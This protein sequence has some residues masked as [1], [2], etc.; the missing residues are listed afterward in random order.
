MEK[1]MQ[2]IVFSPQKTTVLFVPILRDLQTN[3]N[4]QIL[5]SFF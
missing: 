2:V 5:K 1:K 3:K 4:P